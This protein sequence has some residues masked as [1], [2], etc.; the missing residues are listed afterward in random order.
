VIVPGLGDATFAARLF[1]AV[2]VRLWWVVLVAIG[3]GMLR[4]R[5]VIARWFLESAKWCGGVGVDGSC[6]EAST[7]PETENADCGHRRDRDRRRGGVCVVLT[8]HG[9]DGDGGN[10]QAARSQAVVSASGKI[11]P[12]RFVNISA[13]TSGRVGNLAVNEGDRVKNG[14]FLMQIDPR[15]LR[16]RVESGEAALHANESALEQARQGVETSRVQ[17]AVAQQSLTRQEGLWKAQ[18]TTREALERA[19]NDVKIA[20]SS[21]SEREKQVT[22]QQVRLGS[23]RASLASA[24]YDLSKV[25]IESPIEGIITRRNIQE[26]ETAI[27]GTMNNAGTVLLTVADMSVI[28]A[29]VEVDETN[30]RTW[31]WAVRKDHDRRHSRRTFGDTSMR[32]ATA[33][34]RRRGPRHR[35]RRRP[36][37][38]WW[39]CWTRSPDVR[40]GSLHGGH[41]H[42]HAQG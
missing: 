15:S 6:E 24:Q 30:I 19:Q 1:G 38:R 23:D 9:A 16:T 14:Q 11:Q 13:D 8:L 42:G 34:S 12:K 22:T 37:S 33:R 20:Q 31:R 7:C 35:R 27:I 29:E 3:L 2:D 39:S 18:L 25:R 26:G 40:P 4:R 36:I 41:H 10:D 21:L 17:L 28:Q 5:S 32:L